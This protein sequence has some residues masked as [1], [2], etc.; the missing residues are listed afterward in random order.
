MNAAQWLE[1]LKSAGIL[2]AAVG[3]AVASILS[4]LNGKGIA[5]VAVKADEIHVLANSNFTK[6]IADLEIANIKIAGLEKM[7]NALV[8][9]DRNA[10][11]LR[12]MAAIVAA[13]PPP[14]VPPALPQD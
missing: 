9:R 3:T 4:Y 7:V 12:A 10:E 5:K 14:M 6:A 2:A 1:A 13:P 8:E 11:T